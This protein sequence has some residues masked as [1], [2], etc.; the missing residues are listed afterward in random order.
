MDTN[1]IKLLLTKYFDG[2]TSIEEEKMLQGYFT[3]EVELPDE[4]YTYREQFRLMHASAYVRQENKDLEHRLS[5]AIEAQIA[6]IHPATRK[7]PLYRYLVAA[8][9]ILLIGVSAVLIYQ[10]R[11]SGAKDTFEDPKLAYQEAQQTLL[12]VSQKMNKGFEPLSN[13]S[14]ITTGTDKLKTLEKMDESMGMLNLVSIIN[15]SSNLKK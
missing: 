13:V 2:I 1:Q 11:N 10:A 7:V 15:R 8:S 5:E 12:Y 4:L 6:A 9:V 14:K 3:D